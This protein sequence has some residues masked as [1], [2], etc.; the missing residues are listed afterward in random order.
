MPVE[1]GWTLVAHMSNSGGMFDGNTNLLSHLFY[2]CANS[3]GYGAAAQYPT[4]SVTAATP[5]FQ[6]SFDKLTATATENEILF[7]TG[8]KTIWATTSYEKLL[9]RAQ[10]GYPF[11]ANTPFLRCM[12]GTESSITGNILFR[13]SL[14]EDPWIGIANGGHY[15]SI[16]QGLMVWGE[17]NWGSSTV[18]HVQLKNNHGGVNVYVRPTPV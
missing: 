15:D 8:D 11:P 1:N 13:P 9:E 16:G 12:S 5:D 17:N 3:D 4:S 6:C 7:V 18:G 14:F 2:N 10:P